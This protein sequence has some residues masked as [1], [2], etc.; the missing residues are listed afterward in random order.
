MAQIY[1]LTVTEERG[2]NCREGRGGT[3]GRRCGR[4]VVVV[5]ERWGQVRGRVW[6]FGM[7]HNLIFA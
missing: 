1:H 4:T 5:E 6:S 3:G 7:F 2:V